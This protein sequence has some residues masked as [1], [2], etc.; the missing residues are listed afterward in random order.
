MTNITTNSPYE[1]LR[2][3]LVDAFKVKFHENPG[4]VGYDYAVFEGLLAAFRIKDTADV[5]VGVLSD[6]RKAI[7]NA[8]PQVLTCTLWMPEEIIMGAT[9]VDYIDMAMMKAMSSRSAEAGKPVVKLIAAARKAQERMLVEG[10]RIAE[11]DAA[12]SAF[13]GGA[14]V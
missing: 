10:Y 4:R 14:D 7:I 2:R 11:L 8:D 12:I 6:I 3:Q 13:D 5:D 1:P 9:V